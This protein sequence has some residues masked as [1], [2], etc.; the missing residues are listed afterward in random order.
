MAT[1]SLMQ[2]RLRTPPQHAS[3]MA[4]DLNP[5]P[6]DGCSG[7]S[8]LRRPGC[9]RSRRTWWAAWCTVSLRLWSLVPAAGR[10]AGLYGSGALRR[11]TNPERGHSRLSGRSASAQLMVQPWTPIRLPRSWCALDAAASHARVPNAPSPLV[12]SHDHCVPSG[13]LAD[14]HGICDHKVSTVG[15]PT[16]D[17]PHWN[18]SQRVNCTLCTCRTWRRMLTWMASSWTACGRRP[19]RTASA[20]SGRRSKDTPGGRCV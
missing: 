20:S 5:L 18:P 13:E 7:S 6:E 15:F 16:H 3:L 8:P 2:R 19:T 14:D 10:W 11:L 1:P 17:V 9:Q 4:V 12:L